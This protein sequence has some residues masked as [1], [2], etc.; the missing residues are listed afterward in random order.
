MKRL[1]LMALALITCASVFSEP[2]I[3]TQFKK[4]LQD[5]K[6]EPTSA[7]KINF[8]LDTIDELAVSAYLGKM[9]KDNMMRSFEQLKKTHKNLRDAAEQRVL[10]KLGKDPIIQKLLKEAGTGEVGLKAEFDKATEKIEKL[11]TKREVTKQQLELLKTTLAA[12]TTTIEQLNAKLTELSSRE[13]T[14]TTEKKE[15]KEQLEAVKK[16]LEKSKNDLEEFN[17]TLEAYKKTLTPE[18][19]KRLAQQV[20]EQAINKN[21]ANIATAAALIQTTLAAEATAGNLTAIQEQYEIIEKTITELAKDPLTVTREQALK[22]LSDEQKNLINNKAATIDEFTEKVK[23]KTQLEEQERLRLEEEERQRKEQE[24]IALE[25]AAAEAARQMQE[26]ERLRLEEEEKQRKEQEELAKKNALSAYYAQITPH[27]NVI[28]EIA[29]TKKLLS[30]EAFGKAKQTGKLEDYKKDIQRLLDA[31]RAITPIAKKMYKDI[32]NDQEIYDKFQNKAY[33]FFAY[34]T[35]TDN[36]IDRE[37]NLK[38]DKVVKAIITD[39][40]KAVEAKEEYKI[41]QEPQEFIMEAAK[42]FLNEADKILAQQQA[43]PPVVVVP[44]PG[45]KEEAEPAVAA[46]KTFSVDAA[47]KDQVNAAVAPNG[48]LYKAYDDAINEKLSPDEKQNV[49]NILKKAKEK[50]D[51]IQ[52]G[53]IQSMIEALE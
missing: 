42:Y 37:V 51:A 21:K 50:A 14:T 16:E 4:A 45:P 38:T 40:K 43:P 36:I 47:T 17:K 31:Y 26:Q 25:E 30:D 7:P 19:Q 9:Q 27:I 48:I 28:T 44:K 33:L 18:E 10:T 11:K 2:L 32:K 6:K 34:E 22:G 1:I 41:G 24:R 5:F 8:L 3:V 13:A 15:L 20:N 39:M 46:W 52:Q 53:D 29:A 23:A 49:I 35:G 12:H